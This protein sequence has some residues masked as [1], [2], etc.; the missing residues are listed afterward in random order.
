MSSRT[1]GPPPAGYLRAAVGAALGVAAVGVGAAFGVEF[2]FD[3]A[4]AGQILSFDHA[5][6]LELAGLFI[7]YVLALAV[8]LGG[9]LGAW[10]AL[11]AGHCSRAGWTAVLSGPMSLGATLFV[12]NLVPSA[13][14]DPALEPYAIVL[15]AFL[16][17]LLSRAVVFRASG[18]STS[19]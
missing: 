14:G 6:Q 17:G 11:R 15:G 2:T 5:G 3:D 9:P 18:G 4:S 19:S 8:L 10:L 1:D 13:R 7:F 16:S 12:L